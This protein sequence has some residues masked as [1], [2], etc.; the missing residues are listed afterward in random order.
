M[1]F[2]KRVKKLREKKGLTRQE[3]SQALNITYAALSKYE[4]D[5][6]FPSEDILSRIADYFEV[7]ID[8]L[9]GRVY[10]SNIDSNY[11]QSVSRTNRYSKELEKHIETAKEISQLEEDDQRFILEMIKKLKRNKQDK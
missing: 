11:A 8:E 4:T 3:L 7:S 2:G 9:I 10:S 5:E 6:R 1:S